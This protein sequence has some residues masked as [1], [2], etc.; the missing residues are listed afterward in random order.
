MAWR[1][2]RAADRV[3]AGGQVK[4]RDQIASECHG[5]AGEQII[6]EVRRMRGLLPLRAE[7]AGGTIQQQGDRRPAAGERRTPTFAPESHRSARREPIRFGPRK[8]RQR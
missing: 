7:R 3:P 5:V 2:L 1:V 4:S 6:D 8:V